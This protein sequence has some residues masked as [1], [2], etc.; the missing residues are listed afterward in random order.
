MHQN[1]IIQNQ[2]HSRFELKRPRDETVNVKNCLGMH[3][4]TYSDE[5]PYWAEPS[6]QYIEMDDVKLSSQEIFIDAK[7]PCQ[8]VFF[9]SKEGKICDV[10]FSG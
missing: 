7:T 6:R 1:Y 9:K 5:S 3:S 2:L 4:L 10:D 8:T